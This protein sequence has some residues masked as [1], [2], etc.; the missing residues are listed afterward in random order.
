MYTY[1]YCYKV[2]DL[3]KMYIYFLLSSCNSILLKILLSKIRK[4]I[5][6]N[7]YGQRSKFY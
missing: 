6:G 5:L 7:Q 2:L 3:K 4:D 1:S